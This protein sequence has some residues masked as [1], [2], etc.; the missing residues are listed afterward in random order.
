M[1]KEPVQSIDLAQSVPKL[2]E[3]RHR[4]N[5]IMI[6][7]V[8]ALP[9]ILLAA[10]V[11]S[12]AVWLSVETIPVLPGDLN[13]AADTA[14]EPTRDPSHPTT[15]STVGVQGPLN[16][17]DQRDPKAPHSIRAASELAV[18]LQ[19]DASNLDPE[20]L[21]AVVLVLDY[22]N[23][24][25]FPRP[26]T[27]DP[28]LLISHAETSGD[29]ARALL[30]RQSLERLCD[31]TLPLSPAL[32][33]KLDQIG[34][35]PQAAVLDAAI[36]ERVLL[37]ARADGGSDPD[38]VALEGTLELLATADGF[39]VYVQIGQIASEHGLLQRFLNEQAGG[40]PHFIQPETSNEAVVLAACRIFG[41]CDPLSLVSITRCFLL[42]DSAMGLE[43]LVTEHLSPA[44]LRQAR[45]L[46]HHL[47]LDRLSR[48]H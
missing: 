12:L 8:K 30:A 37:D 21:T 4:I 41:G 15:S 27:L 34:F 10:L 39:H 46:A 13:T 45:L 20:I 36:A 25:R 28:G 26:S 47:V 2:A 17:H 22:C 38:S 29:T 42:C 48:R 31:A 35:D 1:I 43:D 44:Q 11:A 24:P 23:D 40:A 6:R 3:R 33:E 16:A 32:H 9:A 14:F 7:I 18:L 5:P 19:E